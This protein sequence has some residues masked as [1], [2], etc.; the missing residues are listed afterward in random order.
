MNKKFKIYIYILNKN[1]F[2]TSCVL[3]KKNIIII[4]PSFFENLTLNF[5]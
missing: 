2:V 3:A 4:L 1:A 5:W